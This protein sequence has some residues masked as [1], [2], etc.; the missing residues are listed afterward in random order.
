MILASEAEKRIERWMEMGGFVTQQIITM[1]NEK[2]FLETTLSY[3]LIEKDDAYMQQS[4]TALK[5]ADK[6]IHPL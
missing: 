6:F 3:H 5:I 2:K 1:S 4:R